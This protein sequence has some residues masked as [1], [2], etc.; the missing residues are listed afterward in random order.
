[1]QRHAGCNVRVLPPGRGGTRR[2]LNALV[3]QFLDYLTFERGL[4]RNTRAAYAADLACFTAFLDRHGV[5]GFG[6][7]TRRQVVDY[8][9][10]LG[11]RKLAVATQARRL[12][13]IK[14]LLRYLQQEG[15]LDAD[16]TDVMS[17][18]KLWRVLP[19]ILSPAE[20]EQ[21][22]AAV[23]GDQPRAV[24]DRAI[25]E[26]FYACGLRVSE[27]ADLRVSDVQA[28]AGFLRCTGKGSKQRVVPVGGQALD[29]LARYL[30]G[31]RPSLA[32][33]TDEEHLFLTR[34]GRGFT[35]QTLYK[36]IVAYARS[37]GLGGRVTPHTLR[38]CFASHLLANGA[39]LRAIQE[40]LGHADIA[41]TQIYTHV[42]HG[43]LLDVHRRFHPRS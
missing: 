4:S 7:L 35:R 15:L 29:S 30:S 38:H 27:L 40:M 23:A 6:D 33:H 10:E 12:V 21:L 18:P 2:A 20:V 34:L 17:S 9:S 16:V 32:R 26:L 14:V 1:M 19:D 36:L 25:L 37:A 3:A 28:E 11:S 43:R 8:L 5:R 24:R 41:T 42:D 13:A 31:V 39:E 22:L